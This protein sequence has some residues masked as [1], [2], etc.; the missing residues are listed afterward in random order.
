MLRPLLHKLAI[1]YRS[2]SPRLKNR[3]SKIQSTSIHLLHN[4]SVQSRLD[5]KESP[6]FKVPTL[7][8]LKRYERNFSGTFTRGSVDTIRGPI[9]PTFSRARSVTAARPR[10]NV[11]LVTHFFPSVVSLDIMQNASI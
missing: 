11:Y 4:S 10:R 6:R 5:G 2:K 8:W 9:P 3:S 7:L 1:K